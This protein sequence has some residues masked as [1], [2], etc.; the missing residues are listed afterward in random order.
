MV[1]SPKC[2]ECNFMK[3]NIFTQKEIYQFINKN[4]IPTELH[5]KDKNIPQQMK[6]WGIFLRIFV[7]S[8]STALSIQSD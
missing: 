2:P 4:F 8:S 6:F 1:S 7:L 5:V 3:K